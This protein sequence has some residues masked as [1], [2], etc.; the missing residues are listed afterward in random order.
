MG[1][2]LLVSLGKEIGKKG[3]GF[4]VRGYRYYNPPAAIPGLIFLIRRGVSPESERE[5]NAW[6]KNERERES[7]GGSKGVRGLKG[8]RGCSLPGTHGP[9][10]AGWLD[11]LGDA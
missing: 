6:S 10:R 4:L 5:L 9:Q 2:K 3:H 8:A 7:S 11:R 1:K